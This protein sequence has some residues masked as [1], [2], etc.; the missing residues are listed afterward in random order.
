MPRGRLPGKAIPRGERAHG[1]GQAAQIPHHL[2]SGLQI[3]AA[4]A[5][6]RFEHVLRDRTR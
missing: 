6:V 2:P 1:N 3:A 4:E 5:V